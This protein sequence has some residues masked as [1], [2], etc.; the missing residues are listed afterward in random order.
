MLSRSPEP[1]RTR[2]DKERMLLADTSRQVTLVSTGAND[3]KEPRVFDLFR[4]EVSKTNEDN[5]N[6][7]GQVCSRKLA[8]F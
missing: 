1:A 7:T 2:K 8:E 6:I 4:F 5:T 3:G